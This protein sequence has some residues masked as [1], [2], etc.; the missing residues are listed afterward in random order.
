LRKYSASSWPY[1]DRI[2]SDRERRVTDTCA[3]RLISSLPLDYPA[4][5]LHVDGSFG[6][7]AGVDLRV[8]GQLRSWWEMCVCEQPRAGKTLPPIAYKFLAIAISYLRYGPSQ[9]TYIP[10]HFITPPLTRSHVIATHHSYSPHHSPLSLLL[11][12]LTLS[13]THFY[14]PHHS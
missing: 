7:S 6:G 9:A 2:A 12:L 8:A 13:L 10:T 11:S 14:T 4:L 1:S 5:W 3:P